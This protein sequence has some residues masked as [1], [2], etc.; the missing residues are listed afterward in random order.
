MTK[1]PERLVSPILT[2][3]ADGV[4]MKPNYDPTSLESF[5]Q[6]D[7]TPTTM[8]HLQHGRLDKI[9][10]FGIKGTGYRA[11]IT[12][13]WYPRQAPVWGLGVRHSDWA[14]HLSALE[15][16]PLGAKGEWGH[17]TSTFL[18]DDGVSRTGEE[19]EV[20]DMMQ[21]MTL[22]SV[23]RGSPRD[24]IRKLMECLM[25]VS[26]IAISASAAREGEH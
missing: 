3:F 19:E 14:T 4:R 23:A 20:V 25:K 26:Q 12:A 11:E 17:T 16:L 8:R 24:G 22:D 9:Y 18:P 1:I 13:M 21:D 15:S 5:A 10:S 2:R 7:Q 6:W